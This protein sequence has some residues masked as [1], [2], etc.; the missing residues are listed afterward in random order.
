MRS[1]TRIGTLVTGAVLTAVAC[2]GDSGGSGPPPGEDPLVVQRTAV[3]SGNGQTGTVGELLASELR[4]AITR[5]SVPQEGEVV[6]W[7]TAD[8]GV[9][10]PPT[11]STGADGIATTRWTL[12]PEPGTQT[13]TATVAGAD[14]SPVSFTAK[15]EDDT[16]PPPPPPPPSA[17]IQVLGPSGGNRFS[18]IQVTIQVGQTVK[19]SWPGGSLLHNVEPDAEEPVGSGGFVSGPQEYSFTFTAAGTYAYYC[20]HHGGPGGFGM[21]GTVIVEP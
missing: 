7:A 10:A 4:V 17:T 12:G 6:S 16:P 15:A 3:G 13:A 5:T 19:W 11:S 20:G 2:G 9:L 8:G 18:P 21:S 1:W 14:G